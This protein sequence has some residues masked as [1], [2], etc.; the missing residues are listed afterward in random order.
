[1]GAQPEPKP[2]P[3]P[4]PE[5][6]PAPGRHPG[7]LDLEP[8]GWPG[9]RAARLSALPALEPHWWSDDVVCLAR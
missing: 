8:G 9:Q 3:E 1:M 5:P 7:D 2:E 6:E 4:E